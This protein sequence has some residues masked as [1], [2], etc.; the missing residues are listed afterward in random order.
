M[1]WSGKTLKSI[2]IYLTIKNYH[3]KFYHLESS[4]VTFVDKEFEEKKNI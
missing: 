4:N 3:S 1:K 2:L